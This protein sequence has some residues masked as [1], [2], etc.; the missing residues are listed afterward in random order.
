M[1][2][3]YCFLLT[4][5]L[6]LTSHLLFANL[7]QDIDKMIATAKPPTHIGIIVKQ[8]S[9]GKILYEHD[10]RYL[11]SPASI[12]KVMTATAALL[13]LG[14]DFR[15]GTT[16]SVNGL[17]KDHILRGNVLIKFTGDPELTSEDLE[18]L[19]GALVKKGIKKIQGNVYIDQSV[20]DT[21]A[22]PPGWLQDDLSYSY[23]APLSAVNLNKNKFTLHLTP[24]Q[25]IGQHPTL[26]VDIPDNVI[27][28]DNQIITTAHYNRQCPLTIYSDL[29]NHFSLH[30]CISRNT[31]RWYR[32]LA[33]RDTIPYAMVIITRFLKTHGIT[34]TGKIGIG[35]AEPSYHVLQTHTSASLQEL[36]KH[37]LK[38]SDNLIAD[39]LLKQLGYQ[40][41]QRQGT[42]LNGKKALEAILHKATHIDFKKALI[43][44]GAGMSRY[45]LTTPEQF[46]ILLNYIEQQPRSFRYILIDAL[47]IGG[48]DGTLVGRLYNQAVEK[49]VRAKTGSMTGVSSLTGYIYSR[50]LGLLIFTIMVNDFIG[51]AAPYRLLEDNICNYLTNYP[52]LTH[53]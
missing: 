31:G 10:S 14:K 22:Y 38:K 50:H 19:L 9:T 30:G 25:K 11:F 13:A 24:N 51:K 17:V 49:R 8:T 6:M 47:P 21:I 1:K 20:Y 33:V 12:Q 15:F 35:K 40:A 39:T 7:K 36:L 53:G 42:W 5:T 18:K 27:H 45:N 29:H 28:F 2:K 41:T 26:S 16:L 44:D 4:L 48:I 34:Y 43:D 52:S 46:S 23:A 3:K 37:M 32:S